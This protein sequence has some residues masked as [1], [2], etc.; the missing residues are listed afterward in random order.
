MHNQHRDKRISARTPVYDHAGEILYEAR[1]E[2]TQELMTKRDVDV[3]TS[4]KRILGLRYRGP[5]PAHQAGG[6]RRGGHQMASPH[7][8]ENYYNVRGM[9]H[10]DRVPEILRD[11]FIVVLTGCFAG[12]PT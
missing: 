8:R 4:K 7:K 10:I 1:P 5:D 2:R 3:I 9:W 12:A 6:C 11:H